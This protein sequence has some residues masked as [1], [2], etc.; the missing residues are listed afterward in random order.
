M[1]EQT[2]ISVLLLHNSLPPSHS[3]F[4]LS[5]FILVC[6]DINCL[7]EHTISFYYQ[8]AILPPIPVEYSGVNDSYLIIYAPFFNVLVVRISNADCVHKF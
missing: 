7:R 6:Y 2:Y 8:I 5:L 1:E 4:C 3:G